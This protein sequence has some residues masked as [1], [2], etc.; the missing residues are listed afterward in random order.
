MLR[1]ATAFH[2]ESTGE[3]LK[4]AWKTFRAGSDHRLGRTSQ[5][6]ARSITSNRHEST[7]QTSTDYHE[8]DEDE[9]EARRFLAEEAGYEEDIVDG[10]VR[11]L[12][13]P[14]SGIPKGALANVICSMA[15]RLEVGE[16]AGLISLAK[17]VESELKLQKGKDKVQFF[18]KV[19]HAHQEFE[20]E[21]FEGETLR[22]IAQHGQGKG[23]AL[24]REF[25]ECACSG[26]MACSTC[27]VIVD[28]AWFDK[29][30]HPS[31]AEAV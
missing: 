11:A 22:D 31:D 10:I 29:V 16:D 17:S 2:I 12:Q 3:G 5:P 6:R 13:S 23:A 19:P 24:L 8:M 21:G 14:S 27:H 20:V 18:V 26:V 15:G 7:T 25:I 1:G 30:G 9:R 4:Y 28:P